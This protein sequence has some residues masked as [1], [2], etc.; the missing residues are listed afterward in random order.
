MGVAGTSSSGTNSTATTKSSS[1]LESI[2]RLRRQRVLPVRKCK[3][4]S[5]KR[6]NK[7]RRLR[8]AECVG[9][10][11]VRLVGPWSEQS[12]GTP[13]KERRRGR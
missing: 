7:L 4:R 2:L 9:Q 3:R 8:A 10:L 13:A 5:N 6:Q 1:K 11:E 12:P